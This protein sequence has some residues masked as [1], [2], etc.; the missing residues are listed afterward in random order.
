[1]DVRVLRNRARLMLAAMICA[2]PLFAQD[3]QTTVR[4]LPKKGDRILAQPILPAVFGFRLESGTA[5]LEG[6][7]HCTQHTDYRTLSTVRY[8]VLELRCD[9]GTVLVL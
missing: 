6:I 5:P 7:L 1:R 4:I 8:P 9:G 2:L 3:H